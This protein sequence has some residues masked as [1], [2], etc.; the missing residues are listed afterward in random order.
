MARPSKY[1]WEVIREAYEKGFSK[2]EIVIK[3]HLTRKLL[4]DKANKEKWEVKSL[5][6]DDIN[7]LKA[8][9]EKLAENYTKTPEIAEMFEVRINTQIAD[10][11]LIGNN[12]KLLKGFQ[13][14]ITQGIRNKDMY[15]TASDIRAGVGAL[16]DIEA[17]A[18]P[19]SNK[20]DVILN[21]QTNIQNNNLQLTESEA[22]Q[23][24]LDLGVPLSA[25]I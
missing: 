11:E 23:K 16:K 9:S 14:L 25:L 3:F 8:S 21:N 7:E 17:V 18:N 5:V 24:A 2:D 4:N 22:K 15:K 6:M 13:G 12:R 19:Q 20:T 10:N 1:N